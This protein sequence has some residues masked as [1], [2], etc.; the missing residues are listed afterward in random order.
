VP[1]PSEAFKLQT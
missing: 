1:S